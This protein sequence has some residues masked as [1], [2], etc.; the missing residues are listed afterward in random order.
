MVGRH[1]MALD[2]PVSIFHPESA[3][4]KSFLLFVGD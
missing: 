2:H 4:L 3:Y 1:R